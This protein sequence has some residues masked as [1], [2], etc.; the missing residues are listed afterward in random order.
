MTLSTEFDAR[1]VVALDYPT[2]AAALAFIDRIEDAAESNQLW[3]KVGLE[4]FLATGPAI[5]ETLRKRGYRVFLDLKLHD[6]PNTVA[7]A[8]RSLA[9]SGASLLTIHATGGPAM[10]EAAAAARVPSGPRLLA[11]TVLTSMNSQQLVATGITDSPATQVLRLARLA[12]AAGI[13]GLVCSPEETRQLRHELPPATLLVVPGIRPAGSDAGDQSRVATPAEAIAA[14]ASMLV[15]GRPITG[16]P[17]PAKAIRAIFEE[18]R[19]FRG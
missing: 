5:V 6:I 9:D 15:I 14:G 17:D 13:D 11:V 3:L 16:A 7:R 2:T 18:L 19:A 12:T 8:V 1:L 10:L 4:L